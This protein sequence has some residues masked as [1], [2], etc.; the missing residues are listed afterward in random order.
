ML[1]FPKGT[2]YTR[3]KDSHSDGLLDKSSTYGRTNHPIKVSPPISS[4]L[5]NVFGLAQLLQLEN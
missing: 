2:M 3:V 1:Q 4:S 5:T